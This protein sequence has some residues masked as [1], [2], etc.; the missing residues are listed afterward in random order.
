MKNRNSSLSTSF[1]IHVPDCGPLK[2]TQ[3]KSD[4]L[5]EL[6]TT[7]EQKGDRSE[8]DSSYIRK[9]TAQ[10]VPCIFREANIPEL[11]ERH[12]GRDM[13]GAAANPLS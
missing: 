2:S 8:Y 1:Q 13:K 7:A 4:F 6:C 12:T 3:L 11:A 9:L 5:H 10:P